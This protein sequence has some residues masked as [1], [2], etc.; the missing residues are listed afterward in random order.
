MVLGRPP[1]HAA[2]RTACRK[3]LR[4]P[5]T[6]ANRFLHP[7]LLSNRIASAAMIRCCSASGGR[8][9]P[10]SLLL[11]FLRVFVDFF[12]DL[13]V[14]LGSGD[15]ALQRCRIKGPLVLQDIHLLCATLRV[16]NARR[17]T[18]APRRNTS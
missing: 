1:V 2:V 16:D 9:K 12:E 10:S 5:G 14:A 4:I 3:R 7:W 11:M 15:F 18:P 6:L 8:D 17:S 13:L